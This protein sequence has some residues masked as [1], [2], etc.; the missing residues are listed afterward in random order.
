MKCR[1]STDISL[2]VLL[3]LC[4]IFCEAMT[5]C[6]VKFVDLSLRPHETLILRCKQFGM[7]SDASGLAHVHKLPD[8]AS[9]M[10]IRGPAP[11]HSGSRQSSSTSSRPSPAKFHPGGLKARR[12]AKCVSCILKAKRNIPNTHQSVQRGLTHSLYV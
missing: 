8:T 9:K 3:V 6:R 11:R 4:T 7:I 5:S 1:R 10:R 12:V 2:R